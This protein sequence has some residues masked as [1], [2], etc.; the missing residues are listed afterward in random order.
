[1]PETKRNLF[2]TSE[3]A[4][5][6][7]E[8]SFP[9]TIKIIAGEACIDCPECGRRYFPRP[10]SDDWYADRALQFLTTDE[11]TELH[12]ELLKISSKDTQ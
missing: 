8:P 12:Q 11:V 5:C 3:W 10:R 6:R 4:K 7:N 2:P 1:M 9:V